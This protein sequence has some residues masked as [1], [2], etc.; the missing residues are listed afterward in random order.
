MSHSKCI[1][2]WERKVF[3]AKGVWKMVAFQKL[4]ESLVM[5]LSFCQVKVIKWFWTHFFHT[6]HLV[7]IYLFFWYSKASVFCWHELRKQ[8]SSLS[9]EFPSD[10]EHPL[11]NSLG[12]G[13]KW[14]PLLYVLF[15]LDHGDVIS[16][17]WC[18]SMSTAHD[19]RRDS[20][21]HVF[22]GMA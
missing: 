15:R 19:C 22:F 7:F 20:L 8:A 18:G 16:A 5:F 13:C 17:C 4:H 12:M 6:H 2:L 10:C 14:P 1:A 21:P 3:R 9:G 11:N